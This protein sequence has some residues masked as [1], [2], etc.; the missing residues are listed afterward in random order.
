[1]G[2]NTKENIQQ[3]EIGDKVLSEGIVGTITKKLGNN[4]YSVEFY[5][6]GRKKDGYKKEIDIHGR[7]LSPCFINIDS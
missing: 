6:P 4:M 1:M 5:I 7:Q 2:V 3:F